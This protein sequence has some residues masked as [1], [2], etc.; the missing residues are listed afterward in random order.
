LVLL[1]IEKEDSRELPLPDIN[2][3]ELSWKLLATFAKELRN[4]DAGDVVFEIH[5]G[6]ER[7]ERLYA[8]KHILS[9]NSEY[10]SA[11]TILFIGSD[12]VDFHPVWNKTRHSSLPALYTESSRAATGVPQVRRSALH[13]LNPEKNS[14]FG[15]KTTLRGPR[16]RPPNDNRG[17]TMIYIDDIDFITM[18]NLLY[19]LYTRCVNLHHN[20]SFTQEDFER[21]VA[22][23]PDR[24]DPFALYRAANMYMLRDLED[25][26]YRYLALT[27]TPNNICQRL[28]GNPECLYYDKLKDTYFDYIIQNYDAV[29]MTK[30]WEDML[31]NLGDCSPETMEYRSKL[32]LDISKMTF[33]VK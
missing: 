8:W 20:C 4:P 18:H 25:L 22:G 11:S 30:E 21:W 14:S 1:L 17:R 10:F 2:S 28:L 6:Y 9:A 32:L 13:P 31:L 24:A 19:F 23:Y 12:L 33:G 15:H 26:C 7:S 3:Q 16:Q 29:K 5:D 27:C